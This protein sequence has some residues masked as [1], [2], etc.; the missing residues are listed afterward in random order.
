MFCMYNHRV[1]APKSCTTVLNVLS[2]FSSTATKTWRY[3]LYFAFLP[4]CTGKIHGIAQSAGLFPARHFP[5]KSKTFP[6]GQQPAVG[7]GSQEYL[8]S[9]PRR[10]GRV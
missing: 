8:G 9:L 2:Y 10:Q 7:G 4:A 1:E 5:G 6:S 3:V